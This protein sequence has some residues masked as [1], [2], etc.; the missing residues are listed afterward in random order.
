MNPITQFW[1][2]RDCPARGQ[3]G[4]A[5]LTIH[6]QKQQR[7]RC[8]RSGRTVAAT[9]GT[10]FYRL[11]PRSLAGFNRLASM[12]STCITI[13]SSRVRSTSRTSKQMNCGSH[14]SA[15]VFGRPWRWQSRRACGWA[16]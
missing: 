6:C 2:N 13:W 12:P 16:A 4:Q 7:Y 1:H 5:N 3:L 14:C 15:A 9:S 8:T 11:H 10:P